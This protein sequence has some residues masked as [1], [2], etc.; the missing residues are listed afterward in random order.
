MLFRG[1]PLAHPSTPALRHI[2]SAVASGDD[3]PLAAGH[4]G[5]ETPWPSRI[6]SRCTHAVVPTRRCTQRAHSD[7]LD[8]DV[9]L[10]ALHYSIFRC[11]TSSL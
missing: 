7:P 5:D 1:A 4:L 8:A 2:N 9:R 10:R 3:L 11:Y 6:A